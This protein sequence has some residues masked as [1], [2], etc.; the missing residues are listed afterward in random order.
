M[1]T[2]VNIDEKTQDICERYGLILHRDLWLLKRTDKRT[3]IETSIW[4]MKN[5]A[6]DRICAVEKI[7]FDKIE[8]I[9]GSIRDGYAILRVT[10]YLGENMVSTLSS[11]TSGSNG[12]CKVPYI[13]EMAEKRGRSRAVLKL[14]SVYGYIYGEDEV[15]EETALTAAKKEIKEEVDLSTDQ[16]LDFITTLAAVA[17]RGIL[18]EMYRS[19]K[20]ELERSLITKRG[21]EIAANS[22]NQLTEDEVETEKERYLA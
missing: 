8:V 10:A 9:E 19:A 2:N 18:I 22:N 20:S 4:L 17:D 21:L 15:P 3:G 13:Y 6:I 11:A 7:R 5:T 1:K 16:I 14:I 12:T